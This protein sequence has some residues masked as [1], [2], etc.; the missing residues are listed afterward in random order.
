MKRIVAGSLSAL[1]AAAAFVWRI[2]GPVLG[3]LLQVVAALIV[4]FEEWGWR[5]LSNALA[6][7]ARF[8]PWAR[9]ELLIAGLPPYAAL[10]AIALPTTLLF[11]LKFI[12]LYL[13]AGG[14]FVSAAMLFVGAKIVSTALIAR[15]FI[16]VKPALMQIAWFATLHDRFVPW[17]E[18]IF[19]Q[20]RATWAWRYGRMLK[21]AVRVETKQA[22]LRWRPAL[23]GMAQAL[24]ARLRARWQALRPRL[25]VD[26]LRLRLAARRIWRRVLP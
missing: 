10:F 24:T 12:A 6:R 23:A 17:K 3:A 7:L 18:A 8:R 16:L 25:E 15:V 5:P 21:T 14:H 4:L 13:I 22:W 11:P 1:R 19:A 2:V 26:W 9:A 20:I